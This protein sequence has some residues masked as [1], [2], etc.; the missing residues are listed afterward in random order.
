MMLAMLRI[1]KSTAFSA[2]LIVVVMTCTS[3]PPLA[4]HKVEGALPSDFNAEIAEPKMS[5]WAKGLSPVSPLDS[6]RQLR[7]LT[8]SPC[9]PAMV[10]FGDPSDPRLTADHTISVYVSGLL[11]WHGK[12]DQDAWNQFLTGEI[13]S[14]TPI[15][16]HHP[17]GTPLAD[18]AGE[19]EAW[20][21]TIEDFSQG[22]SEVAQTPVLFGGVMLPPPGQ[23]HAHFDQDNMNR[24]T[25]RF[26]LKNQKWIRK[27][28]PLNE[29]FPPTG[30]LGHN[31]GHQF[32]TA[33]NGD[34]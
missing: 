6:L 28:E 16:L 11:Q 18:A 19:E 14:Y 25:Y 21:V 26:Q 22:S 3:L 2:I 33:K 31:Y 8:A 32:I 17:D 30:W 12:S 7:Q 24:R 9:T 5:C 20:D 29:L 15:L 4:A 1:L 13:P 10:D 23:S 34:L 27:L